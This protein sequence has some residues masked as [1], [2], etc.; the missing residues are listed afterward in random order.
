MKKLI[1][2]NYKSI[3]DRGL[4]TPS[5]TDLDFFNKLIEEVDEVYTAKTNDDLKEEMAD[6]ILTT[7][8]WAHHKGF[9]IEKELQK[10]IDKN[11]QR[12]KN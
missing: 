7:L 4:I 5:T 3:V 10:K 9:D 8:N 12:V 1:E 11:F 2:D 6:V